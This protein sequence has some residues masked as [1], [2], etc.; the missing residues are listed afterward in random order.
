MKQI[1]VYGIPNCNTVKKAQTWLQEAGVTFEFHN[2]KKEP[3]TAPLVETW[4]KQ[5]GWEI[6]INK[7]GTTYRTLDA[8]VKESLTNETAAKEVML[9]NNSIIKRPVIVIDGEVKAVGFDE[10]IYSDLFSK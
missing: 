8:T 4:C 10:E 2:F 9:V 3:A 7:K 1:D 6:L 5:V